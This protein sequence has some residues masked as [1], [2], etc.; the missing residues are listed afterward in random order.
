MQM[1]IFE[2]IN[3]TREIVWGIGDTHYFFMIGASAG[4]LFLASLYHVFRIERYRDSASTGLVVALSL[5]LAAPLNLIVN[6]YQPGR[7]YSFLYHTH[8]TSPMSWG[9]FILSFYLLSLIIYSWCVFRKKSFEINRWT[10]AVALL[11]AIVVITY[12][13]VEV[14]AVRA[15]PLWHSIMVPILYLCTSLVSAIGLTVLVWRAE[16]GMKDKS[17][18]KALGNLLLWS[19]LAVFFLQIVWIVVEIGFGTRD[20][21]IA[22]QYLL[23]EHWIAFL[24]S[25]MGVTVVLPA[26]LLVP[27]RLRQAARGLVPASLLAVLGA[28]LFRW[29]VVVTGQEVP[30]T[31][32]GFYHYFPAITGHD[33]ITEVVANM[34]FAFFLLIVLTWLVPVG[35]D[36]RIKHTEIEE[37]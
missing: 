20:A 19:L 13:G 1:Q 15:V 27:V 16:G 23:R 21:R 26:L 24:V 10:G 11:S 5:G 17:S 6:L 25:G 35:R 14:A 33:S 4:A 29:N 7:F 34:A 9:T 8:V 30:K 28:W 18:G 3:V 32:A 37:S 2:I 36:N 31:S 22:G 12:T